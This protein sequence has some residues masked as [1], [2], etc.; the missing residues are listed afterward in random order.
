S[1]AISMR[2]RASARDGRALQR[3]EV[4]GVGAGGDSLSAA[5]LS[6][7][8]AE[9]S[10]LI[11]RVLLGGRVGASAGRA[12]TGTTA[13]WGVRRNSV[14]AAANCAIVEYRSA[15]CRAIAFRQIS[16]SLAGTPGRTSLGGVGGFSRIDASIVTGLPVNGRRPVISS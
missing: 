8:L 12:A 10:P 2:R 11:G 4:C 9:T 13:G 1:L 3:V 15:G 14:R 7:T 5:G 6:A 16:S